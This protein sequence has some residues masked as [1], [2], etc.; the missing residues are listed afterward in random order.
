MQKFHEEKH[1]A[2]QQLDD[3]LIRVHSIV[4]AN[5][6]IEEII[7]EVS[8]QAVQAIGCDSSFIAFREDG[9]WKIKYV[10]NF[11]HK[12]MEESYFDDD[13]PQMG[14]AANAK[15]PAV[16]SDTVLDGKRKPEN[17]ELLNIKSALAIPLIMG[18]K[19]IGC[20]SL[21][22]QS[23]EIEFKDIEI[24]FAEKITSTLS[25]IFNNARLYEELSQV[26]A[27]LRDEKKLNDALGEIN[28]LIHSVLDMDRIINGVLAK[29][30]VAID[31]ES[32]MVFLKSDEAQDLWEVKYV[33]QLPADLVGRKYDS[34][35]ISHS[36]IAIE[37]N[38][39][40]AVDDVRFDDRVDRRFTDSLGIK[41][42]LDF[43][44]ITKEKLLGDVVFHYHSKP[45]IFT[46]AHIAFA[47]KLA[48]SLAFALENAILFQDLKKSEEALKASRDQVQAIND[49][50]LQ[51]NNEL[52]NVQEQLL[53]LNNELEQK[54]EQRTRKLQE[55]QSQY[56]HAA[57]LSAIGN[58]SA[59]I[60]HEFNNPLQGVLN[61]LHGLKKR[62]ILEEEDKELLD[63]AIKENVRMKHLI[64]NLQDFNRPSSGVKSFID[65]HVVLDSL[66]MFCKSDFNRKKINMI[67][68]YAKRLPQIHAVPDQI[69]QVF[70]NLLSNAADA[71]LKNG[72]IKIS[73]WQEDRKVAIAIE[74]NGIGIESEKIDRIFQPFYTTKSQVKGTGL[75]LSVS[76][77]IVQSHQGGI[78]VKSQPGEG[79][80]F[81]V[82]LPVNGD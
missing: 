50:L 14:L 25:F 68:N 80:T 35:M 23:Q 29:G 13:F 65:V 27:K 62:A 55:T 54:V 21:H 22:Y 43:P 30:T 3:A 71:C 47:S 78:R 79:S 56:L 4:S 31:A 26:E 5:V 37:K 49:A 11:P 24:D 20:L 76:H 60:A 32:A 77:G 33:Y 18:H 7:E 15:A 82:L 61:I 81:T 41:S 63:L 40:V 66:L 75:G 36:I 53:I 52:K 2:R 38:S 6:S 10:Y 59:S 58:L 73:T 51:Q 39:P 57:K 45:T 64:R 48:S 9:R 12:V 19:V 34:E 17:M 69:K 44:L 72:V 28:T 16:I 46:D 42:L 1:L 70:L 74:D 67:K 8:R